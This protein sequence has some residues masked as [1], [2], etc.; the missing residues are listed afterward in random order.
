ML[1][2]QAI[3]QHF[4]CIKWLRSVSVFPTGQANVKNGMIFY[5]FTFHKRSFF[6]GIHMSKLEQNVIKNTYTLLAT[7][8]RQ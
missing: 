2:I 6:L 1:G 5:E 3:I 8:L 4:F 7:L